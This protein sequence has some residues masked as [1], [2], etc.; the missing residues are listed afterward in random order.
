[1]HEPDRHGRVVH[2]SLDKVVRTVSLPEHPKDVP[3]VSL[4]VLAKNAESVFGRL[5]DNVGHFVQ[6]VRIVLND[7]TDASEK[8][9]RAR[10]VKWP[11]VPLDIQHVTSVSHSKFYFMDVPEAYEVGPSL[12]GEKFEGPFTN[13]PLLC[14]WA[15]VRN[16]GWESNC[17]WRLFLDSDDLVADPHTLPGLLT[18]LSDMRVDVAATKYAYGGGVGISKSSSVSYRER[19]V[20][21]TPNIEWEGATHEVLTGGLRCV[22]V[23]DRFSVTDMKDNWGKGVRVPG[24]CF[25]V[26]Y[27]E[28]RLAD[29]KVPARNLAYLVQEC[30]SMMPVEWVKDS[31]LPA[32]VAVCVHAEEKAWVLSM[33]GEMYEARGQHVEAVLC[34]EEAVEAYSSAKTAFRLCRVF[35]LMER[36]KDCIDAYELGLKFGRMGQSQVLDLGPVY[37]DA[38][39]ILVA[40]AHYQLGNHEEARSFAEQIAKLFPKSAAVA[41]LRDR[42]RTVHPK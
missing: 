23:E 28:A 24:R 22:L 30:P 42:I 4:H 21:N 38:S 13:A 19:L 12:N 17:E 34:Y 9:V 20:R 16:L 10:M 15:G 36:W 6:E 41:A 37:E 33:V 8:V 7:T 14:D 11:K 32:Y 1:M 26:L 35:F 29:W 27:R 31:L 40:E 5:L 2:M 39:K 3:S 25:K 18:I